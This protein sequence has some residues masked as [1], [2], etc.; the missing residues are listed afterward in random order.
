M[1]RGSLRGRLAAARPRASWARH[2][3]VAGGTGR[4][5]Q[6]SNLEFKLARPGRLWAGCAHGHA[7]GLGNLKERP[8]QQKYADMYPLRLT[9]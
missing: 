5:V 6:A 8:S 7:R 2:T 4:P 1:R 9:A 3:A